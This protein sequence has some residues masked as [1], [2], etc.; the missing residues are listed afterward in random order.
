[1]AS[2]IGISGLLAQV[3]LIKCAVRRV[4]MQL[5]YRYMQS[6]GEGSTVRPWV[7]IL[8]LL[9]GPTINSIISQMN[10]YLVVRHSTRKFAV[11]SHPF[12]HADEDVSAH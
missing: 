7:W 10:F 2:P 4:L 9:M 8:W 3:P 6:G 12:H 1:M 11:R 5:I